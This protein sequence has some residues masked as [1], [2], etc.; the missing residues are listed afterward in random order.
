MIH[1]KIKVFLFLV[2]SNISNSTLNKQ[3][4]DEYYEF[5]KTQ[6]DT[7]NLKYLKKRSLRKCINTIHRRRKQKK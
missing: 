4:I 5:K 3:S 2:K 1:C 6:G 7:L